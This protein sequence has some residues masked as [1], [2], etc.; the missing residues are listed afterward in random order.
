MTFRSF[1]SFFFQY[2]I[3]FPFTFFYVCYFI[4][5]RLRC[6]CFFL[7]ILFY[8]ITN[9]L[10]VTESLLTF[11][12]SVTKKHFRYWNFWASVQDV[13]PNPINQPAISMPNAW[14]LVGL[15]RKLFHLTSPPQLSK[16]PKRW[17]LISARAMWELLCL[18]SLQ[19]FT[20]R[21]NSII[22]R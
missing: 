10:S 4:Y 3:T 5:S 9:L 16:L 8:S 7:L 19:A 14:I 20:S 21:S 1:F 15:S 13:R 2:S 22:G 17:E 18:W 11:L 12:F 6:L